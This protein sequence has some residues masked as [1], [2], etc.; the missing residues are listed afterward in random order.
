MKKIDF[1][2]IM[3]YLSKERA[4]SLLEI[5]ITLGI[6]GILFVIITN[7]ILIN[8]IAARRV[9][10]RS[11]VRE[12]TAFVLNLL[13]KDIRNADQ[14]VDTGN[15]TFTVAFKPEGAGESHTY[16]WYQG[17]DLDGDGFSIFR[18][19][20]TPG[21]EKPTYKTPGDIDIGPLTGADSDKKLTIQISSDGVNSLVKIELGAK[22]VGMP[23][24]QWIKKTVAA[25]TRIFRFE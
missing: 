19:D 22:T 6:F 4:F 10:A 1:K 20:V 17:D 14:I 12:E 18:D 21:F 16:L 7:I 15:N 2:V 9:A 25:S 3:N 11:Y 13:K 24:D 8:L 23:E 5:L